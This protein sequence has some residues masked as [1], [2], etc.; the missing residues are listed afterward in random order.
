MHMPP[1]LNVQGRTYMTG[2]TKDGEHC[3]VCAANF[4]LL[5]WSR[6]ADADGVESG[7]LTV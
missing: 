6:R 7:C 5:I 2:E 1:G 3:I 4:T